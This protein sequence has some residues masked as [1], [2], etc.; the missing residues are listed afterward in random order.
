MRGTG[1]RVSGFRFRGSGFK[2][3]SWGGDDGQAQRANIPFKSVEET[4]NLKLQ[5][6]AAVSQLSWK[7]APQRSCEVYRWRRLVGSLSWLTC[8]A[9]RGRV[10]VH[11]TNSS[12]LS[13]P[14]QKVISIALANFHVSSSK[15]LGKGREFL[16]LRLIFSGQFKH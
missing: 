4:R 3:W 10:Y 9:R 16:V 6:A 15:S 7:H 12:C 8:F 5:N 14:P 11:T 1:L 13:A 2:G